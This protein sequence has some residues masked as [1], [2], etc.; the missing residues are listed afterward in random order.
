MAVSGLGGG[1]AV[2]ARMVVAGAE[3]EVQRDAETQRCRECLQKMAQSKSRAVRENGGEQR[4]YEAPIIKGRSRRTWERSVRP[5]P[6][7]APA[8]K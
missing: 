8:Q 4:G 5:R 3:R 1:L 2:G 6:K 7:N